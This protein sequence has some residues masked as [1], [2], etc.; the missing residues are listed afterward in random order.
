M[1]RPG[2][3]PGPPIL[4][5]GCDSERDRSHSPASPLLLYRHDPPGR[6]D[7]RPAPPARRARRTRGGQR[8]ARPAGKR[9]ST[10]GPAEG[11]SSQSRRRGIAPYHAGIPAINA[12]RLV[13]CLSGG[14]PRYASRIPGA[15]PGRR[16]PG[17]RAGEQEPAGPAVAIGGDLHRQQHVRRAP[18]LVQGD[19]LAA[20]DGCFGIPAGRDEPGPGL[21][22]PASPASASCCDTASAR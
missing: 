11:R 5:P 17:S 18:D 16:A 7:T 22:Y 8:P 3:G 6:C 12:E 9:P 21:A 19:G 13:R 10:A 20:A 14:S 2:S 4:P 15:R 1:R